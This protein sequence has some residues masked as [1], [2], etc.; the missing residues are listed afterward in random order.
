MPHSKSQMQQEKFPWESDLVR[1]SIWDVLQILTAP[2]GWDRKELSYFC[3]RAL[4]Y[5]IPNG[6]NSVAI[7]HSL[8]KCC[9]TKGI[10]SSL[11]LHGLLS[12]RVHMEGVIYACLAL[13]S[14]EQAVLCVVLLHPGKAVH[15]PAWHGFFLRVLF[16]PPIVLPISIS[17]ND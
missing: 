5:A 12:W 7:H 14:W 2:T 9:R 6:Q 8:P 15:H 13:M 16:Y 17:L 10:L 11:S 3:F 1:G 4:W